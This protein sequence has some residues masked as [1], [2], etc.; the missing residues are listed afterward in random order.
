MSSNY[1]PRQPTGS[2]RATADAPSVPAARSDPAMGQAARPEDVTTGYAPAGQTA[3]YDEGVGGGA[4]GFTILAAV[5][6]V[7]GG[8]WSFFTGLAAVIHGNF[9]ATTANYAYNINITGWGWI[10]IAIGALVFVAGCALF[11]RQ[12]WARMVGI[13]LAGISAVMNFLYIPRYPFWSILIIA[14]DVVIIWA[15]SK[16]GRRAAY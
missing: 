13:I 1:D 4:Q 2:A 16:S 3:G 5:L 8:L 7:L 11:A 10:H 9:F 14:L 15:L 6:M 12:T